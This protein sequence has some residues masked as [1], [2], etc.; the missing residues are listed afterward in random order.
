MS[1]PLSTQDWRRLD[2]VIYKLHSVES[3]ADLRDFVLHEV[4]TYLGADFACW[5]EY[6][7][8]LDVFA[9]STTRSHSEELQKAAP[10]LKDCILS[11][12]LLQKLILNCQGDKAPTIET[13]E[14][15]QSHTS[16]EQ[17]RESEY[18]THIGSKFEI[19]DQ[20]FTQV[21]ANDEQGILL[22]YHSKKDFPKSAITKL[23][24]L[25]G[26]FLIKLYGVTKE[27][28]LRSHR[29]NRALTKLQDSLTKREIEVLK[30]VCMGRTNLEIAQFSNISKRTVDK[31]VSNILSKLNENSRSRLI[32]VYC[33]L[34]SEIN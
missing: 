16:V 7:H 26:H 20:L 28:E 12:P 19:R 27:S 10:L 29:K 23:L 32:A 2:E 17:F 8:P 14:R 15:L 33:P 6:T 24:V 5:T 9:V 25:R 22:T 11:H 3:Y 30:H 1:S 31:H 18:Y 21:C 34:F 13:V 4:T